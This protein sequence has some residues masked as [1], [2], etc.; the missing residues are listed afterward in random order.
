MSEADKADLKAA[1]ER[2]A[3]KAAEKAKE[4]AEK[5]AHDTAVAEAVE[6]AK[7]HL[8]DATKKEATKAEMFFVNGVNGT[9][10]LPFDASMKVDEVKS[11]LFHQTGI[12]NSEQRQQRRTATTGYTQQL[13]TDFS[14]FRSDV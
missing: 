12:I 5:E 3:K 10:T 7:L 2:A 1:E 8:A 14:K 6:L 13:D 9:I 4:E 11:Q